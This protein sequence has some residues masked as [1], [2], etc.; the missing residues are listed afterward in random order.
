MS[1]HVA[2]SDIMI[3]VAHI[4]FCWT[5]MLDGIIKAAVLDKCCALR[6]VCIVSLCVSLTFLGSYDRDP[7]SEQR[8]A[9]R[10]S[11]TIL[12]DGGTNEK[13]G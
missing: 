1:L 9:H 2:G 7:W 5:E 4:F 10:R 11:D 8:C 13:D 12:S 3:H 6:L